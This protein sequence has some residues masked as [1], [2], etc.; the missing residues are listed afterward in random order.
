MQP[1]I[2]V[3]PIERVQDVVE[4]AVHEALAAANIGVT[5][6]VNEL[7]LLNRKA[8]LTDKEVQMLYGINAGTLGNMRSQGRGPA[9]IKD[10]KS[11]RYRRK[12]VE[13]YLQSRRV[14]TYEQH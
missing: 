12:D 9:F 6:E 2:V 7:E 5:R 10:G 4:A 13:A 1:E 14:K 11:I 8:L 3:L